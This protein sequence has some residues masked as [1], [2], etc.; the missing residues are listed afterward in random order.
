MIE[1][2][3][4]G[5]SLLRL[6]RPTEWDEP[7]FL[8]VGSSIADVSTDYSAIRVD[9]RRAIADLV[10]RREVSTEQHVVARA[11][12]Y[13]NPEGP[14]RRS[15]EDIK[16]TA[17]DIMTGGAECVSENDTVVEVARMMRDLAVGSLPICGDDNRLRGVVT[18]HDIV[19]KCVAEG[20]NPSST[21]AGDVAESEPVTVDA[22]DPVEEI[23][24]RMSQY[25]V[26]RLPVIDGHHL[27]GMVSRA[28]VARN[29]PTEAVGGLAEKIST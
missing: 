18:A 17:R 6:L 7:A 19:V 2:Q 29:L 3:D 27:I 23:L 13:E 1:R 28:D 16:T 24:R 11:D 20:R 9:V 15:L 12:A 21:R 10:R 4:A 26:R 14:D 8:E 25:K 22:D 5:V